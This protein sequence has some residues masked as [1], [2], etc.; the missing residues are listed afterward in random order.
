MDL[1][2]RARQ[3]LSQEH[4]QFDLDSFGEIMDNFIHESRCGLLVTK[5]EGEEDFHVHGAGC[6]AVVNFYIFMSALPEI[7]KAMLREMGGPKAFEIN[8]LA[9]TIAAMLEEEMKDAAAEAAGE[10]Q[11]E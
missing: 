8:K 11:G 3:G 1:R 6:G 7:F 5:E 10:K 4:K 9:K 2:E